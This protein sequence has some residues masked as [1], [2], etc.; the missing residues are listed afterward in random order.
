MHR[1]GLRAAQRAG[2]RFVFM[3]TVNRDHLLALAEN[4]A[5]FGLD[6]P[7]EQRDML[8]TLGVPG[9]RIT[10][11]VD[12]GGFLA[13]KRGAMQAHASQIADTSFF[14][15]MPPEA[16]AAVWGTEWYMRVGAEP[17]AALEDTLLPAP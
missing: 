8:D 12:V 14:L 11:T 1:V 17:G 9:D 15:S 2:T 16:F 4:A 3:A 7:D 13:Q 10:T 6:M 5:Q